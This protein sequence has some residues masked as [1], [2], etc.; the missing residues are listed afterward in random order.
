MRSSLFLLL[1]AVACK[2]P[3][4]VQGIDS[5]QSGEPGIE[6]VFPTPDMVGNM[7]LNSN[8]EFEMIVAVDLDNFEL[9]N[10]SESDGDQDGQ[11]HWHLQI[12][13]PDLGY[14]VVFEQAGVIS[15]KPSIQEN[16]LLTIRAA[17]QSNTHEELSDLENYQSIIEV[18]VGPPIDPAVTCPL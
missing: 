15:D 18:T 17:L 2:P 4:P 1:I 9:I 12:A 10:P 5:G 7:P 8:C 13:V 3:P 16:D 14:D 11:G 6:I